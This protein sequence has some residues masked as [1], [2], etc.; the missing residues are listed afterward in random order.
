MSDHTSADAIQKIADLGFDHH[1]PLEWETPYLVR[2]SNGEVRVQ[3]TP[4]KPGTPPKYINQ[5]FT[6]RDPQSFIGYLTKH[7]QGDGEDTE[8]RVQPDSV[9][10]TLDAG[11][12]TNPGRNVHTITL[13]PVRDPDWNEWL[14][15]DGELLSQEAF[16]EFIDDHTETIL[17][18]DGATM[19]EIAQSMRVNTSVEF[20]QGH[21]QMDGQVRF[22]WRE[23]TDSKAGAN[24]EIEIPATIQLALTPFKGG[25]TY[26]VDARLRWRIRNKQL[27][28]GV[29]LARPD[30]VREAAFETI[31]TQ[32]TDWNDSEAGFGLLVTRH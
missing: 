9:I 13:R 15:I 1:T 26:T 17:F 5:H 7:V 14:R 18:P 2:D 11:T 8:I 20:E 4:E 6:V 10:A 19:L 3:V 23:T 27:A 21:R 25:A 30:L 24:G 12:R 16:A 28:I 29:K 31:I 22:A 32:I